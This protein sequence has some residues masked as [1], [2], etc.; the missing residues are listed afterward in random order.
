M[1][2]PEH[3]AQWDQAGMRY[4]VNPTDDPAAGPDGYYL[5]MLDLESGDKATA[6]YDGR[7]DL[8]KFD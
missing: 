3:G 4:T 8:L 1:A 5:S 7:G 2:T 6:V